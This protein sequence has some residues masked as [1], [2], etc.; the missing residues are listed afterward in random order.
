[1]GKLVMVL[2]FFMVL[3]FA[4]ALGGVAIN[5]PSYV[6]DAGL[7]VFMISMFSLAIVNAYNMHKGIKKKG[8]RK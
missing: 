5:W 7:I 8:D 3:S 1:M 6:C 4:I 2:I